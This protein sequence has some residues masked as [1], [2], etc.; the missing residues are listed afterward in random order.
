MLTVRTLLP[1]G[2]APLH[3]K[4]PGCVADHTRSYGPEPLAPF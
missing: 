1:G 3:R 2:W 4:R